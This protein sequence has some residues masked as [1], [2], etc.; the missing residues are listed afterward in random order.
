MYQLR[1]SHFLNSAPPALA[2][3][4]ESTFQPSN[5]R[6]DSTIQTSNSTTFLEARITNMTYEVEYELRYSF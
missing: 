3:A 2:K 6:T 4:T 1:N 5:S